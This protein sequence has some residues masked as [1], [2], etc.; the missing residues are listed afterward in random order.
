MIVDRYLEGKQRSA[1]LDTNRYKYLYTLLDDCGEVYTETPDKIEV[2]ENSTDTY[3][4]V[5]TDH[6]NRLD[7]VSYKF[8]G[9]PLLWWV[10]AEASDIFNPL[11]VPVGTVLR[12]P[13]RSTLYG[14]KG[15]LNK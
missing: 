8:Y 6:E 4:I 2:A 9:T 10:I 14:A 11:I 3:F 7:L 15:V 5:D 12:V 13:V 1:L